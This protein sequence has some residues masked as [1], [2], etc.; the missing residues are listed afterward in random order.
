MISFMNVRLPIIIFLFLLIL[1]IEAD[2]GPIITL[3]DGTKL[4]GIKDDV[5]NVLSFKGIRYAEAPVGNFRWRPPVIY[6]NKDINDLVNA[7]KFGNHCIQDIWPNGSEDCLFLNVFIR[8]SA[9]LST[10]DRPV[11]VFIHGGSYISGSA[12]FYSGEDIVDYWNGNAV[13]VT[14]DYRLN[15]FGFLGSYELKNRDTDYHSCG[16]YGIQDQRM[17]FEWIR[18]NIRAFG[19]SAEKLTIMGQSAGGGSVS[20]HL[21]MKKSWQYVTGGAII[22]S[23]SFAEWSAQSLSRAQDIY[24]QYL[25]VL[26]CID[27]NCLLG[28]TTEEVYDAHKLIQYN[29]GDIY[30]SPFVPTVDSVEM[31]THP[32]LAL[33]MGEIADVPLLQGTNADEGL[34][35][36]ALDQ[37]RRV[38]ESELIDYWKN[39]KKYSNI[40]ILKLSEL[41][42]IGKEDS[43]PSS[44]HDNIT[45]TQWWALMRSTG[46]SLFSCPAKYASQ[47]LSKRKSKLY[48]YHFEYASLMSSYVNHGAELPYVFHWKLGTKSNIDVADMM[49]SYFANFVINEN[50]DINGQSFEGEMSSLPIWPVYTYDTDE[51]LVLST[52]EKT[53]SVSGLKTKECEFHIAHID[54]S[55]RRNF[56]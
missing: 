7:T 2:L 15:V 18:Q 11:V 47:Q 53:K 17:G 4:L 25:Q 44:G 43:Y 29:D 52:P 32:W 30:L 19:G 5:K 14:L 49:S 12:K 20:N 24:D 6:V 9:D 36:T 45:T 34:L 56:S 10:A 55:I 3:P 50:H 28:K 48:M 42:V 39:E 23:G 16:N 41:Y 46:D 37:R 35:F 38:S 13:V 21:T 54:A 8:D 40:D 33:S 27:I 31:T 22:E 26:N 51:L 1:S